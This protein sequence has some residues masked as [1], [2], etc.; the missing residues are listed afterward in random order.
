VRFFK[1][2][3]YIFCSFSVFGQVKLDSVFSEFKK[4]K[5]L[6]FATVS[7]L[8]KDLVSDT[9]YFAYNDSISI[10]SASTVKLF[11]TASAIE[12]LGKDYRPRTN[13]YLDNLPDTSGVVF[14]NLYIKGA[15]D[16]SFASQYFSPTD[17]LDKQV[18]KV[19]DTLYNLGIRVIRGN[20][21]GDGSAFG[22]QGAPDG[23]ARE[24]LGNYYGAFPSGLSIY[25]NILKFQFY[26]D[27]PKTKPI[28]LSTFPVIP[29]LTLRNSLF[30]AS[31]VGDNS[32]IYGGPYSYERS[33]RG[34]L[35]A[36]NKSFIVKGSMP[37]P[38]MQFLQALKEAFSKKG[39][40][41]EGDLIGTRT[42]SDTVKLNYMN[43]KNIYSHFGV[44]VKE[45]AYWTN[46]KS[47]NVFAETLNSWIGYEKTGFGSTEN[48]IISIQEF[49]KG[50]IY[51]DG[52]NL[53]DGSGL[54]RS[55]S[56][57]ARNFCSLLKYMYYSKNQEAFLSTLPV[58]GQTGTLTYFCKGQ[59]SEGKIQA[60]SGTMKRVKSYAGYVSTTSGK[61]LAFALI[62]NNY[63][64]SNNAIMKKMETLM[65]AM[66]LQ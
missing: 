6:Q 59:C 3:I 10:V 40:I 48:G 4:D 26:V 50:K 31:G 21:I 19:A 32:W 54:S 1:F 42:M 45:I 14:G 37:D 47:I 11:T 46:L 13:F 16:I 24:D 57:S 22:Y 35:G 56:V 9:S 61:K 15:A 60:K 5:S 58:S 33:I 20:L 29:N 62:V 38:E 2:I 52:M 25:D 30:S 64:C 7:F 51:T 23:W 55:N 43:K 36:Y 66:Y 53:T 28:L 41:L 65:N 18:L 8:V 44:T 49:W 12:I 34:S 17:S 27:A 39:I 63:N